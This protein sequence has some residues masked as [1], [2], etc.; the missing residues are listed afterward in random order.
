LEKITKQ[1]NEQKPS[2]AIQ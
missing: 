2:V 1:F